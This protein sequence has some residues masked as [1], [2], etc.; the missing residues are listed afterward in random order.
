MP[1]LLALTVAP[2]TIYGVRLPVPVLLLCMAGLLWFLWINR[3]F[4]GLRLAAVGV[5]LNLLVIGLNGGMPVSQVAIDRLGST[6][7]IAA[8]DRRHTLSTSETRLPW[9]GDV[10]VFGRQA[11]SIGDVLLA[12]GLLVFLGSRVARGHRRSSLKLEAETVGRS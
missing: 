8:D 6:Q 1:W 2:Q 4:T 11:V 5:A 9:L 10:I 12:G 7:G 3:S